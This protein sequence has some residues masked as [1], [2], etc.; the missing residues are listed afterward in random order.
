MRSHVIDHDP[1]AG[2]QRIQEVADE[3]EWD[4]AHEIDAFAS[5]GMFEG[6]ERP[7]GGETLI[8]RNWQGRP[9]IFP[10]KADG[11]PDLTK[12]KHTKT[13]VTTFVDCLDD[14]AKIRDWELRLLFEFL[15]S[16]QGEV[17]VLEAS[18]INRNAP[19][20]KQQM[21]KL[22]E[23]AL[24]AAGTKDAARRGTAIHALTERHD[25]GMTNLVVPRR[26]RPHLEFYKEVTQ[27]FEMVEIE[28]F[29]V[30]DEL[31]T[32]G[33]PDR[34]IR[35]IP[36]KVCGLDLF[37]EDLKTGRVDLYTLLAMCMQLAV[38]AH[39]RRYDIFSG[40]R[41]PWPKICMHKGVVVHVPA[42]D[43]DPTVNGKVQWVNIAKGWSAVQTAREVRKWRGDKTN[44]AFPFTPVPNIAG[45]LRAADSQKTL[46]AIFEVH[47]NDWQSYLDPIMEEMMAKLP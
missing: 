39:S 22:I 21:K 9:Y 25:M 43:E 45:L 27:H 3:L 36:C 7:D 24:E 46:R 14:K 20:Y 47:R 31:D 12:T 38:Y 2:A 29:T 42:E 44:L 41:H 23:R 8:E 30:N 4:P 32:G 11:T 18:A 15:P 33:T 16:D 5:D 13:R 6:I 1:F 19:D 10:L 17:F 37:I 34:L 26:Y 35:Y 40:E 28:Q